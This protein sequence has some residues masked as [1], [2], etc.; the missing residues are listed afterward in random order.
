[1][2]ILFDDDCVPVGW[3]RVTLGDDLD[4]FCDAAEA[5]DLEKAE[6]IV[7]RAY[8]RAYARIGGDVLR[9]AEDKG[10]G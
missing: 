1:M 2:S 10:N 5:G 3:E 8:E 4:A 7:E 9:A 6:S